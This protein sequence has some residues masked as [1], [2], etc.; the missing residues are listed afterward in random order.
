MLVVVLF[1]IIVAF[2]AFAAF[3]AFEAFTLGS[4]LALILVFVVEKLV[5]VDLFG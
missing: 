1:A 2:V 3:V 4:F 5:E